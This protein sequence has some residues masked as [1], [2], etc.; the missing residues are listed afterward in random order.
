MRNADRLFVISGL[1][2]S[3]TTYLAALL[4]R[5][6][7]LV[8]LSD[9]GGVWR[10]FHKEGAS[11]PKFLEIADTLVDLIS[12]GGPVPTFEGT[13]GWRGES[14]IDTWNQLK[15]MRAL[16]VAPGFRLGLKNP[17]VFLGHIHTLLAGGIQCVV[18][19]RHPALII[20]SWSMR[21][22]Q[23]VERGGSI[24]GTFG[25][26]A[27][28]VYSST[29]PTRIERCVELHNHLAEKIAAHADHPGL[30]LVRHEDWLLDGRRQ[31][32]RVREFLG[33][34]GPLSLDPL[35][36]PSDP[37]NL[38]ADEVSTILAHCTIASRFGYP[39]RDGRLTSP[40]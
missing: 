11:F 39:M 23:R 3:G 17:E 34:D 30:L 32:E 21:V 37:V 10:R 8:T 7:S 9:T 13:P 35:P 31:L 4:H 16:A 5:P 25:D 12:S 14:R 28:V 15:E 26:G 18:S 2:R 6:P 20:N 29:A 33:L 22:A 27:S 40:D 1:P 24:T 38:P 36:I 19:V